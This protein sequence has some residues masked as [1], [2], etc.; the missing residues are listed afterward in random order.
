M[1]ARAPVSLCC[2]GLCQNSREMLRAR[3]GGRR[4]GHDGLQWGGR[5][6]DLVRHCL[7]VAFHCLFTAFP[8]LFADFSLPLG[9]RRSSSSCWPRSTPGSTYWR[10]AQQ[11]I[12]A[13]RPT[14]SALLPAPCSLL[15]AP[16]A[17]L[18]ALSALSSPL[19]SRTRPSARPIT[20]AT[21]ARPRANSPL[22]TRG[23]VRRGGGWAHARERDPMNVTP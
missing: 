4:H 15:P 14:S 16:S 10:C 7:S 2:P 3:C 12:S 13:L 21:A 18:P 20:A 8:W 17:L 5:L 22:I 19:A 9:R 23:G 1:S 11:H 6:L